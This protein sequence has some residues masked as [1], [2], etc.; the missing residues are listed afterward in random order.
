MKGKVADAREAIA[1]SDNRSRAEQVRKVIGKIVCHFGYRQCGQQ[2]RSR[3][4]GVDI[5]AVDSRGQTF[6]NGISPVPG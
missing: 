4:Q 1:G 3:L 6:S 5:E 2:M